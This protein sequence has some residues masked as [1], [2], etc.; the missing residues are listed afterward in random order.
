MKNKSYITIGLL[1]ML[2]F[3]GAHSANA[4]GPPIHIDQDSAIQGYVLHVVNDSDSILKNVKCII[5]SKDGK[6]S[7]E[8]S[9]DKISPHLWENLSFIWTLGGWNFESGEHLKVTAD[10]YASSFNYTLK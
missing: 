3:V 2:L 8:W 6:S 9:F 4:F 5:T 1:T 7:R 10:S